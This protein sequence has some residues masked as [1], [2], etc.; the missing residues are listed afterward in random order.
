LTNRWWSGTGGRTWKAFFSS[1][2]SLFYPKKVKKYQKKFLSFCM[3]LL[4]FGT[5]A[6]PQLWSWSLKLF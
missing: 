2:G 3:L 1:S 5:Q 6:N 4:N